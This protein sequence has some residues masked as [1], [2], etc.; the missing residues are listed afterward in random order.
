MADQEHEDGIR[1][2]HGRDRDEEEESER[3]GRNTDDEGRDSVHEVRNV[4]LI[5]KKRLTLSRGTKAPAP[6][7]KFTIRTSM[8]QSK[9]STSTNTV[10]GNFPLTFI[11]PTAM[12][13][14]KS[15]EED[16]YV[17]IDK[18]EQISAG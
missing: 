11:P 17:F 3:E 6:E 8:P 10:P 18:Y 13:C 4:K 9:Q 15:L 16:P 7:L 2:R 1:G 14:F 5:M 12:P